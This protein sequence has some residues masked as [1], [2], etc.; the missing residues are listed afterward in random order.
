M[1]KSPSTLF[2]Q[3]FRVGLLLQHFKEACFSLI[4]NFSVSMR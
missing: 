2:K 4:C 3:Q 1:L